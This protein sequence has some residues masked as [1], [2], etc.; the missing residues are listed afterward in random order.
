MV[1]NSVQQMFKFEAASSLKGRDYLW[2][3]KVQ[4]TLIPF[5]FTSENFKIRVQFFSSLPMTSVYVYTETHK[6]R[7]RNLFKKS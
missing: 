4:E 5:T 3:E 6:R 2:N 7:D 1:K